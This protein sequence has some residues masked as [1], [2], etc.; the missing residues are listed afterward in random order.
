[1]GSKGLRAPVALAVASLAVAWAAGAASAGVIYDSVPAPLPGNVAS[2]GFEATSSSE[3]GDHVQFAGA[4]RSL[5]TVTVTMS[6]WGCE[7]GH[8]NTSDCTTTPG[9]TFSHPL[10]LN[11]Y[12]VDDSGNGAG[13]LLATRTQ[14]FEIPFRPSADAACTNGRWQDSNGNCFSGIAAPVTFDF[15][16]SAVTLPDEVIWGIAYNTTHAG[17]APIGEAAACYTSPGG[18]GY[19]SLNVGS[20]GAAPSVGTDPSPAGAFLDSSVGGSYCDSGTAGTGTFRF[21]DGCWGGFTPEARFEAA[22]TLGD[23]LV[24]DDPVAKRYTLFADC[25][26][27]E[28]LLIP[29]KY[30]LDGAGHTIT[31]VDPPAGAFLGAVVMNETGADEMHVEDVTIQGASTAINCGPFTGVQFEGAGGSLTG[32]S[33]LDIRRDDPAAQGCQTGLGVRVNGLNAPISVEIAYS[34]IAGYQKNGITVN[35]NGAA[36]V[37]TGNIV[38]GDGPVDYIAQ[39]GIQ[40]SRSATASI[41]GNTVSGNDYTPESFVA[42]G[43]LFFEANGVKQKKNALFGNERDVCNFGRGGGQYNLEG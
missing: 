19:D 31:A 12:A 17:S 30:T 29:D 35:G 9:A 40:V 21:D 18:C 41:E 7:A 22:T 5:Q 38:T 28:T 39:N 10:T 15:S 32:S 37:I 8:W 14:T 36:A 24:D 25:T 11:L 13:A 26:T 34:T 27:D 43:L 20:Q 1:M 42:C 33:V 3:F 23:C 6:S 16:T 4:S 2:V